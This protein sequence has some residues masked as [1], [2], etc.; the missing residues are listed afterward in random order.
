MRPKYKTEVHKTESFGELVCSNSFKS[1]KPFSATGMLKLELAKLASPV[2][3]CAINSYVEAGM[4]LAVDRD[5]FADK[6]TKIVKAKK[7]IIVQ[8]DKFE[9]IKEASKQNDILILATGPLTSEKLCN[10]ILNLTGENQLSFYDAA[11]PIVFSD[12]INFDKVFLQNRYQDEQQKDDINN[13]DY[14]NC[15][16][17]KEQYTFFIQHLIEANCVIKKDFEKKDL[18]QAC[19]PIEEI[20][21]SGLDAPR[22]GPMKPVG[23]IDPLTGKR[24]Y[25]AVQLRSENKYKTAYNIVGFQTN[26]TF[27]EQQ[28]IFK[29]IPGLENAEFARYGVMHKNSFINSPKLLDKS[30]RLKIKEKGF[31]NI[32]VTGQLSGT[33][34]Y[35]EAVRSG[36]HCALSVIAKLCNINLECPSN[37][38]VFGSLLDYACSSETKNYQPMHVN[39]GIIKPLDKKIKNKKEKYECYAK[40][41]NASFDIYI[42][43]LLKKNIKNNQMLNKSQY[44]QKALKTL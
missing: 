23:L 26:L 40:R 36:H 5:K 32:Y 1:L 42:E 18:F 31:S 11:A 12:S 43:Q 33:E 28:K 10:N 15:F 6:I 3:E 16:F 4:A 24:P 8:I 35:L 39:F 25:A 37:E 20:A 14:I 13:A 22:Y 7:N 41:G 2:F 30:L 19:Q 29:L 34:G 9:N 27:P 44:L 17:N 38:T 21:R